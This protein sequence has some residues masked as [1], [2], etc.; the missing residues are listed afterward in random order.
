MAFVPQGVEGVKP[1][2]VAD[3]EQAKEKRDQKKRDKAKGE[4]GE[5]KPPEP[6]AELLFA[7]AVKANDDLRIGGRQENGDIE[8]SLYRWT[9]GHWSLLHDALARKVALDWLMARRKHQCTQQTARSALATAMDFMVDEPAQMLSSLE[10]KHDTAV[11]P[12]E[13]AYLRI[14]KDGIIR[15]LRPTRDLGLTYTVP[16]AFDWARCNGDG[17]YAPRPVDPTSAFGRYL[18][19]FMPDLA[20]RRLL[21]EAAAASVLPTNFEVAWVLSGSGSNGKSTFLHLL[22]RI[23]P[24]NTSLRLKNAS[25]RFGFQNIAGKTLVIASE[26]PDFIGKD[27]EQ[28]LKSLISRDPIEVEKKKRDSISI[29][30]RA[31][32]FLA[33]NEPI[34]FTDYTYGNERKYQTIPFTVRMAKDSPDRVRDYHKLITDDPAE[35]AVV[36]DWIL[37]GAV[38]LQRQGGFSKLPES[39]DAY[40]KKSRLLTDNVAAFLHEHEA[41]HDGDAWTPKMAIY[42]A[43]KEYCLERTL[44]PV[45]E[46]S[47]WTRVRETYERDGIALGD[48]Q[49]HSKAGR[50]RAVQLRVVGVPAAL[51]R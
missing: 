35:M 3:I 1:S 28:N 49:V 13:E 31:T 10:G 6:S 11:I 23:H 44:K 15:P 17:T 18:D 40:T 16:A 47:F 5:R 4:D 14:E 2:V 42:T 12:V 32:L 37:E 20:V 46:P 21:Q 43:Y 9:G 19:R 34:K 41:R 25:D 8:Q 48:K 29:V 51:E 45:S 50:A 22:R 33:M 26:V 27:A 24:F 30:P 39:V 38:R 7:Q 36:L